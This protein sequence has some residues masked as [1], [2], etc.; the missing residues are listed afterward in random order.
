MQR[1]NLKFSTSFLY[2]I[3]MLVKKNLKSILKNLIRGIL[4]PFNLTVVKRSSLVDFYLHEYKSYDEYKD[5]QI[6]YNKKN[7]LESMNLFCELTDQN[8]G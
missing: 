5:I 7:L 6:F 1:N 2:I 3:A 8:G 4:K